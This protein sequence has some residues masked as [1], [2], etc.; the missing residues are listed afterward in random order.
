MTSAADFTKSAFWVRK[1]QRIFTFA[2]VDK[3]GVFSSE[4]WD[5][6]IQY[7]MNQKQLTERQHQ[8]FT[9]LFQK[10]KPLWIPDGSKTLQEHFP[11][12]CV[13]VVTQV[14]VISLYFVF[15]LGL[16]GFLVFVVLWYEELRRREFALVLQVIA[17]DLISVIFVFPVIMI[18]RLTGLWSLLGP[19]WCSLLGFVQVFLIAF[20]YTSMFLL[21]FDRLN[22]VFLPFAY[23]SHSNKVM[24]SL[25]A[26]VWVLSLL[27]AII[28]LGIRC[29]G[30]QVSIGICTMT[31]TCSSACRFYRYIS[32]CV[33]YTSGALLPFIFYSLMF[34][35]SRQMNNRITAI[36]SDS[37]VDE[38]NKRAR[39]TFLLLFLSLIGCTVP[40]ITSLFLMPL[41]NSRYAEIYL[42]Y[43]GMSATLVYTFVLL[44]PLVIL[45]HQDVRRCVLKLLRTLKMWLR[46]MFPA[47][48]IHPTSSVAP[49]ERN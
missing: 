32:D 17:A 38:S 35:K 33:V 28:P 7:A 41:L 8:R 1:M 47:A 40:L 37:L 42:T 14:L 43:S 9:K 46:E 26:V 23:P 12:C 27:I 19:T 11:S 36:G 34:L 45:K 30:F 44:D 16:N 25:T 15:G 21:A 3:D 13:A 4:D 2:D 48:D 24:I 22:V 31:I 49:L 39:R 18:T 29:Y 6:Y 10:L 20:R 5:K